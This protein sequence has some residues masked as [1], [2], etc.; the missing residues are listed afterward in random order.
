MIDWNRVDTLRQEVGEDTF[1]E[2]VALFLEEVDDVILRLQDR[3]DPSRH[4]QDLHFLKGS[5]LNLGFADLAELCQTGERQAATGRSEEVDIP[6]V[7]N[8]YRQSRATFLGRA[9]GGLHAVG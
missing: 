8:C 1:D 9:G 4:E 5:A 7:I 6:A 2:V 3:P